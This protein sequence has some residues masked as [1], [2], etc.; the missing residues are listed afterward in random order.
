MFLPFCLI[1]I[2]AVY[3]SCS[4][5]SQFW[6]ISVTFLPLEATCNLRRDYDDWNEEAF[7]KFQFTIFVNK[8]KQTLFV[9]QIIEFVFSRPGF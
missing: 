8:K 2:Q 7:P 9:T 1:C 6:N 5:G 3:Y 4:C